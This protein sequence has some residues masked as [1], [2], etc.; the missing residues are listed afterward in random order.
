MAPTWWRLDVASVA[1]TLRLRAVGRKRRRE[2]AARWW[3]YQERATA[4]D[5]IALGLGLRERR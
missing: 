5:L 1:T 2:V 4:V 3:K